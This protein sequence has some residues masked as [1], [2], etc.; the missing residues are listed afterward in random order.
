MSIPAVSVIV[1]VF[2]RSSLVLEAIRSALATS[3]P[4]EVVVVDDCSVDETRRIV[5]EFGVTYFKTA[6]RSGPA[7]ARNL[8]V[9]HARGGVVV[10]VD[11]DVVLRPQSLRLIADD[12]RKDPEL[13]AV[14]L[15]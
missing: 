2:N 4:L 15:A 3:V 6:V 14:F 1:T 5:Q 12:F 13:A 8:G 9:Q 10:F 7:A 11:A